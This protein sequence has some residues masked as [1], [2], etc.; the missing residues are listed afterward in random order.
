MFQPF[1]CPKMVATLLHGNKPE[2]IW[3]QFQL[4]FEWIIVIITVEFMWLNV[5]VKYIFAGTKI[6]F[7]SLWMNVCHLEMKTG[8]Y[9]LTRT[10]TRKKKKKKK[11]IQNKRCQQQLDPLTIIKA[12]R[13]QINILFEKWKIFFPFMSLL[14]L[15]VYIWYFE[16]LK[17]GIKN[18]TFFFLVFIW[19]EEFSKKHLSWVELSWETY[20]FVCI[21]RNKKGADLFWWFQNFLHF[22]LNLPINTQICRSIAIQ[23]LQR[24][25][26]VHSSVCH[27]EIHM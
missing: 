3:P 18:F 21:W 5:N 15:C 22:R 20:N 14:A 11:E 26:K 17:F 25:G 7:L 8:N 16:K 4:W 2:E 27:V 23:Q 19:Q 6:R 13:K 12:G 1:V 24:T 9:L 10:L